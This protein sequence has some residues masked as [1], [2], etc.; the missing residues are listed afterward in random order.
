MISRRQLILSFATTAASASIPRAWAATGKSGLNFLVVG[1]WGKPE[2]TAQAAR[3]AK[4]MGSIADGNVSSFVISTGDNFYENGVVDAFDPLWLSSFEQVYTAS[5]LQCPWYVVLGNHDYRGNPDAEIAYSLRSN[6]WRMPARYYVIQEQLAD[7]GAADFFYLD[8]NMFVD[9]NF[10]NQW[11]DAG[12]DAQE[13]L[14]WLTMVL[15]A[16]EADWKIVV[17]HHPVFSGGQHG[18]TD[19]LIAAVKPLLERYGVQAYINGHDHDLQHIQVGGVHYLTSG[20]GAEVRDT[21][22]IDGTVFCAS[23]LGFL[24]ATLDKNEARM[25]FLGDDGAVLHD[26]SIS[27]SV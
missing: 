18:N 21:T 22:S 12:S 20:T 8:T 13:Q 14:D 2:E 3:V 5:S 23:K 27:A 15:G 25:Q 1:D 24:S 9:V 7:G 19:Q 4:E 11:L 17:G 16:S 10:G 6:R 26:F